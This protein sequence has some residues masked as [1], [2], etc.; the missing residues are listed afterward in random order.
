MS[1]GRGGVNIE[2]RERKRKEKKKG[3]KEKGG[4]ERIPVLFCGGASLIKEM[5][6]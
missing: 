6:F 5:R 1:G 4:K 2:R 3:K